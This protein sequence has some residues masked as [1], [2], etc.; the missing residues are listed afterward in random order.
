MNANKG[1]TRWQQERLLNS[2]GKCLPLTRGNLRRRSAC[3]NALQL[4]VPKKSFTVSALLYNRSNA[5]DELRVGSSQ[6]LFG[7]Y[8][9]ICCV[10]CTPGSFCRRRWVNETMRESFFFFWKGTKLQF[11]SHSR[12]EM[13]AVK[14]HRVGFKAKSQVIFHLIFEL[15]LPPVEA[16]PCDRELNRNWSPLYY[17]TVCED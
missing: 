5:C 8:L 9:F 3:E 13:R 15:Q 6:L 10:F 1:P 16:I 7:L 12:L 11:S 17:F 4:R 14:R 2:L